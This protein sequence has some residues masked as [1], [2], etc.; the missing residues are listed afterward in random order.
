M[1]NYRLVSEP[2]ADLDIEAAF[3]WY[4]KEQSG[5]G[6]EFL[7]ELR[8][9]YNRIVEGPFK[10]PH[11]RSGVRRAL[12]RRFPYVV[13]FALEPTVIVVLAVLHASR[14]PAEWQRRIG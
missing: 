4:E 1:T 11:L 7:D 5:L 14:D 13:Y 12:V 8:A 2:Q 6:L 10:Y 3:Q 9:A